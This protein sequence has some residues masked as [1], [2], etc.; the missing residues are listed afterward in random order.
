[1]GITF[2]DWSTDD[3]LYTFH[4]DVANLPQLIAT[5]SHIRRIHKDGRWL[6]NK[7]RRLGHKII[8]YNPRFSS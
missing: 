7:E 4:T 5:G 3:K 2:N 6:K 8:P 1:M